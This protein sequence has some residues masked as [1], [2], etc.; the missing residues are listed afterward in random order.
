MLI[1]FGVPEAELE[2]ATQEVFVVVHRRWDTLRADASVRGWLYGIARRVAS[3]HR[4][5][6]ARHRRKLEVLPVP[7]APSL[8]DR[9]ADRELVAALERALAGLPRDKRDAFV[10]VEL[11]GMTTREVGELLETSRN[12][13]ASRL[14][15]ARAHVNAALAELGPR[16]RANS[17]PKRERRHG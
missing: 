9:V 10:L 15:A 13:I 5:A 2:D 8:E 12:T 14:R 4:R 11:E 1:H 17:R 16:G 3:T 7:E 6:R